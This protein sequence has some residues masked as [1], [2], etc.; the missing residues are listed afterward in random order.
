MTLTTLA[1]MFVTTLLVI[2][3][4]SPGASAADKKVTLRVGD[5]ARRRM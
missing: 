3:V 5:P 2:S 4:I 1:R